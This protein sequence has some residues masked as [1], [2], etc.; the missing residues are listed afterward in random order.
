MEAAIGNAQSV[1]ELLEKGESISETSYRGWT[2]L[3][4]A[5]QGGQE[6]VVDLLL[7]KGAEINARGNRGETAL[8]LA[9]Y[10]CHRWV[11]RTLLEKGANVGNKFKTN[12]GLW[13]APIFSAS[14]NGCDPSILKYVL[15]AGADPNETEPTYKYTPLMFSAN[16][17]DPQIS[18]VL[19]SAG[20]TVNHQANDGTTPL[21]VAAWNR[22]KEVVQL[23]LKAGADPTISA[24]Q[25][26]GPLNSDLEPTDTALSVAKRRGHSEVVELLEA[27]E[28]MKN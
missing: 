19:L 15:N 23:L 11:V 25:A 6:A 12:N 9:T 18:E 14:G 28:G 13:L 4:Y 16:M 3:H 5:A 21:I 2:A 8:N 27:A 7:T 20:A 24:S 22:N 26:G 1:M 10:H 17:K